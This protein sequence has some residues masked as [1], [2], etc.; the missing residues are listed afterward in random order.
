MGNP[1]EVLQET[2]PIVNRRAEYPIV[3]LL[4][5]IPYRR[6]RSH[7]PTAQQQQQQQ[8]CSCPRDTTT[9]ARKEKGTGK[10]EG[11]ACTK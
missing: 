2:N 8:Y 11:E 6:R 1:E 3:L 5:L 9:V 4:L 10:E 7:S